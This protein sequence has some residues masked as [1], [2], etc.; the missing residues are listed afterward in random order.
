MS[1]SPPLLLSA[2]ILSADF[3]APGA[4]VR[5][6]EEAGV[7][8]IHIDVMDGHFVPNITVGP[9]I[10]EACRKITRLPLDVHLMIEQPERH[11]EAFARAGASLLTIHVENAPNVHRTL[12]QIQTLGCQAG[13][14]INPGTPATSIEAV[15]PLLDM[16][17]VM[18]V[19]PGF[20]GQAFIAPMVEKVEMVRAI[21]NRRRPEAHLQV[22]GGITADTLPQMQQAGADVFVAAT[23][24][25]KYPAGI[26]AGIRALRSAAL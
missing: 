3:T 15:A 23:A 2:S 20:S 18:S 4:A 17:L 7:D 6:A 26:A 5:Q 9:V 14:A 8:W 12:Q 21:L 24:I 22:D 19:N 13:I 11:L 25:F 16:V 10:V 1:Q